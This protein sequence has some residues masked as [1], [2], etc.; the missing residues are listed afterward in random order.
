[1][2]LA[3]A[4]AANQDAFELGP[5]AGMAARIRHRASDGAVVH[6]IKQRSLGDTAGRRQGGEVWGLLN[7][8]RLEGE[9]R[10]PACKKLVQ[11]TFQL[12]RLLL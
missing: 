6:P 4:L 3:G 10:P 1:M 8:Y 2:R 5:M 11:P 9:P 7:T 12:P